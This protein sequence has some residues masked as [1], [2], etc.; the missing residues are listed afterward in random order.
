V[1]PEP[2][3]LASS[4]GSKWTTDRLY[5]GYKK[6]VYGSELFDRLDPSVAYSK[7]PYLAK[8]LDEML[9]MAKSAL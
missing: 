5:K 2:T 8:M 7:C 3:A 6:I 9:T 1:D 4:L